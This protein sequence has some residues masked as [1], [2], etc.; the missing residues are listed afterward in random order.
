VL[1]V[2]DTFCREYRPEKGCVEELEGTACFSANMELYV[3]FESLE[4][5]KLW[6]ERIS[7]ACPFGSKFNVVRVLFKVLMLPSS[8][9]VVFDGCDGTWSRYDVEPNGV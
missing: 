4:L 6:R 8:L 1:V 7:A 5:D 3:E 2:D 9:E